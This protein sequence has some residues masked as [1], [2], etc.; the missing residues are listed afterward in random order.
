[1]YFEI[2]LVDHVSPTFVGSV[3]RHL[4]VSN[5]QPILLVSVFR[6]TW[7]FNNGDCHR[8]GQ[9]VGY[10]MS[11][12]FIYLFISYIRHPSIFTKNHDP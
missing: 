11:R 3:V 7:N 12:V 4:Q 5:P 2:A 8:G 1:M 10:S 9:V 6:I